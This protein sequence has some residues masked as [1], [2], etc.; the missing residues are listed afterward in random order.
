MIQKSKV[1]IENAMIIKSVSRKKY[2]LEYEWAKLGDRS[3]TTWK[4]QK[5]RNAECCLLVVLV[6]LIP[7]LS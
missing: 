2:W 4:Y 7:R 1:E 3:Q 6:L 5:K